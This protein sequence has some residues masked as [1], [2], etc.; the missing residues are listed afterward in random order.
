ML[1]ERTR[2]LATLLHALEDCRRG[3]SAVAMITGARATGKTALLHAFGEEVQRSEALL[4]SASCTPGERS[5][6]LGVFSQLQRNVPE[7]FRPARP[8]DDLAPLLDED[9]KRGHLLR[10][11]STALLAIAETRPVVIVV[12]DVQ[13]ADEL[14]KEALL[15]VLGRLRSTRVAVVFTQ[16]VGAREPRSLFHTEFLRHPHRHSVWVGLLSPRG[17]AE[18]VAAELG[19]RIAD[20]F[21]ARYHEMTGGNPLLLRALLEDQHRTPFDGAPVAGEGFAEAV[22]SCLHRGDPAIREAAHALAVLGTHSDHTRLLARLLGAGQKTAAKDVE[23][24]A[25]MGLVQGTDFRDPAIRE[26]VLDDAPNLPELH[27]RAACL[28]S[29]DGEDRRVVAAHLVSSGEACPA[30]ALPLLREAADAAI[31]DD[32]VCEAVEYLEF[33]LLDHEDQAPVDLVMM[34]VRL[35]ERLAPASVLQHVPELGQAM[36]E[37]RLLGHGLS[38]FVRLLV[39]HGRGDDVAEGLAKLVSRAEELDDHDRAEVAIARMWTAGEYPDLVAD[40][41]QIRLE[42]VGV[43]VRTGMRVDAATALSQVVDGRLDEN[44]IMTAERVLQSANL[45]EEPSDEISS[46]LHVLLYLEKLD[47]VKTWCDRLVARGPHSSPGWHGV[48][49]MVRAEVAYRTGDLGTARDHAQEALEKAD[50]RIWGASIGMALGTLILATTA[51]G[52]YDEAAAAMRQRVPQHAYRGRYGLHYLYARGHYH[53]ATEQLHAA[54]GDFLTCG[55]LMVKWKIDSPGIVPW[56]A[57]AAEVYT[58]LGNH[59]K[60]RELADQQLALPVMDRSSSRG[61]AMRVK[62]ATTD[63][64]Q[65]SQLLYGALE[66][67]QAAG[68]QLEVARVLADLSQMY[69]ELGQPDRA[70]ITARRAWRLAKD[71]Q[72]E[73]LCSQLIPDNE[74]RAETSPGEARAEARW[75]ALSDA[76]RRVAG[77]A[78]LGH[79]N[80]EIAT[81]LYVTVSTV[82][83]HLTKVYRKLNITQRRDLPADLWNVVALGA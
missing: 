26:A 23:T 73:T 58:R 29:Q 27:Q 28:L 83:Q 72:A 32:Q 18:V 66:E 8:A 14:S 62:A 77:L 37:G 53:L 40:V 51:M 59:A 31:L 2:E 55:E 12:D 78:A 79:T 33:A 9:T 68:A 38:W 15:H 48:P 50:P 74:A 42:P 24:L 1:V 39:V 65:R 60:A 44:L 54:L 34:L 70:R 47:S 17:V 63:L 57:G 36:R 69:H 45:A 11:A 16:G 43:D 61:M 4:L 76:E 41:P 5:L 71:C 56:R 19:S 3:R 80:R 20:E 46:A 67:V 25:D 22:M 52:R 64:R 75:G 81:K 13:Y 82:E 49:A 30:W 10:E 35:K 21:G 6:P 7:E